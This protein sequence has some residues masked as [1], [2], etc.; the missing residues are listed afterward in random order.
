MRLGRKPEPTEEERAAQEAKR[1]QTG[2]AYQRSTA[3]IGIVAIGT[4]IGAILGAVDI[5][6]WVTGLIVGIAC[7]TLAAVLWTVKL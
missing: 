5:A 6:H 7:V 1:R 4:A 2:M 3:T